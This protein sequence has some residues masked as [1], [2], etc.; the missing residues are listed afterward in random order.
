MP[1]SGESSR[2]GIGTHISC[3][4]SIGGGFF[5]TSATEEVHSWYYWEI[6]SN[7]LTKGIS[8]FWGLQTM[9]RSV[10]QKY[11]A[12]KVQTEKEACDYFQQPSM[13]EMQNINT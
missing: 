1:S 7:G 6:I 12:P 13:S 2:P 8:L 4:S 5:T 9:L 11:V 3:V 10:L